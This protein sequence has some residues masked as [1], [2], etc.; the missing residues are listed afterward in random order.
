MTQRQVAG[1]A[2]GSLRLGLG[3]CC[4]TLASAVHAAPPAH[5]YAASLLP[6]APCPVPRAPWPHLPRPPRHICHTC[7]ASCPACAGCGGDGGEGSDQAALHDCHQAAG[8]HHTILPAHTGAPRQLP[9]DRQRRRRRRSRCSPGPALC[10]GRCRRP[11]RLVGGTVA[12]RQASWW[13]WFAFA[14]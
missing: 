7:R 14:A 3:C 9:A 8:G 12:G 6:P 4:S 11:A 1:L 5:R 10:Y 2:C 13:H